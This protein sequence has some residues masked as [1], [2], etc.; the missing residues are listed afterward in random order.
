MEEGGS[1]GGG[2]EIE[3]RRKSKGVRVKEGRR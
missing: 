3:E 1:L 2:R